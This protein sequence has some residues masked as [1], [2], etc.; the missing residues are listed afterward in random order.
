M[1]VLSDVFFDVEVILSKISIRVNSTTL[2]NNMSM[3]EQSIA[4]STLLML[5]CL[6]L[7]HVIGTQI[8]MESLY[9]VP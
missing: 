5:F 8:S 2:K 7:L 9:F 1:T 3:L 4:I 6:D